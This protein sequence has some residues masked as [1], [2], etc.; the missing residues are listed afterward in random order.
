MEQAKKFHTRVIV[1]DKGVNV[2]I[3]N[4]SVINFIAQ[5]V[6]DKLNLPTEKLPKPYQVKWSCHSRGS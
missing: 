6:I 3:D 5:E 2:I 4:G 1:V